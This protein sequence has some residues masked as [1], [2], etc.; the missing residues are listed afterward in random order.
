M[1]YEVRLSRKA[2]RDLAEAIHWLVLNLDKIVDSWQASYDELIARLQLDP[3]RYARVDENP[4]PELD[5]RVATFG[6]GRQVY[7]VYFTITSRSVLIYRIRHAAR[8][9]L[10]EDDL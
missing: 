6:K 9:S 7:L 3:G 1:C 10:A 5:L 8:D 4:R 2:H